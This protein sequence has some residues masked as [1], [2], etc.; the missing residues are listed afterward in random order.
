MVA[1]KLYEAA[2]I[3]VS[4]GGMEALGTILPLL[5]VDYNLAVLIVL[6]RAK[7]SNDFLYDFLN[8]ICLLKVLEAEEKIKVETGH[9]YIA[10]PDYHLQ[11]EMDKT[12]SLSVDPPVNFSRPSVDVLFETAAEAYADKLVGVVLTGANSDGAKGLV[13][14]QDLGGITIIQ[15]PTMSEAPQMPT[16]AIE[17]VGGDYVLSL[18]DIGKLLASF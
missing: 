7:T 15:D 12:L 4:A 2:V 8:D 11:V 16:A 3:G 14:I 6:H 18:H 10:P 17:A 1:K 9:I 5:P 13:R